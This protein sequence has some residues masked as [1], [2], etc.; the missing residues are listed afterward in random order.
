MNN[1]YIIF[2]FNRNLGSTFWLK[3]LIFLLYFTLE[4]LYQY[5]SKILS[6]AI[7]C[8]SKHMQESCLDYSTVSSD[9]PSNCQVPIPLLP[10]KAKE[11][12][13]SIR[14]G[15][16]LDLVAMEKQ[17]KDLQLGCTFQNNLLID[18]FKCYCSNRNSLEL[19]SSA[20]SIS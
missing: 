10:D 18:E 6:P 2:I 4:G 14:C 11:F 9:F 13:T 19:H 3:S 5:Q 20:L 8:L 15:P 17:A 1:E 16:C 7:N 12:Q